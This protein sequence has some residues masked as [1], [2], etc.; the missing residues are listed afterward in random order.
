MNSAAESVNERQVSFL[1]RCFEIL[2]DE[3]CGKSREKNEFYMNCISHLSRHN[4]LTTTQIREC[5]T[6]AD[7]ERKRD[8][9]TYRKWLQDFMAALKSNR[10]RLQTD[11]SEYDLKKF[12]S[13]EYVQGVKGKEAHFYVTSDAATT[14]ENGVADGDEPTG[15]VGPD[16][17]TIRYKTEK[18]SRPPW[19][20]RIASPLFRTQKTRGL[21]ALSALV[22]VFLLLPLAIGY[23]YLFHP[24]D[25]LLV[26]LFALLLAAD[27]M[28]TSP[29]L[30]I[31]RLIT[32]KITIVD[33]IRLPSSS[34]CI[35]EI[36][37][38]VANNPAATE[39]HLSVVT[40][41]ANCPICNEKYG[42]EN[43]VFLEQKGLTNS[44]IIGICY[45]NPMMHR[46]TFDKDL[47][48]GERLQSV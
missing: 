33:S 37:S 29:T 5:D 40:V 13:I 26:A 31:L 1:G 7:E 2:E 25:P 6:S 46:Y 16:Y 19:Y 30:K 11:L 21:S 8:D 36:T 28:L 27:L 14:G 12:P 22:V 47:M 9:K 34:V 43:S 15:D 45:N 38:L 17:S 41:S 3:L 24:N 48:T 35:S 32:R 39:R 42:L 44:R 23:I 4:Y 18:I 10:S 20:L